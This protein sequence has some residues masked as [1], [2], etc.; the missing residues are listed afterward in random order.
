MPSPDGEQKKWEHP[1]PY[2]REPLEIARRLGWNLERSKKGH[3]FGRLSCPSGECKERIFSTGKGGESFALDLMNLIRN[4]PHRP[5]DV[6]ILAEV[7]L[8]IDDL[9]RWVEAIEVR[10]EQELINREL[11]DVLNQIEHAVSEAAALTARFDTLAA[12]ESKVDRRASSMLTRIS[13]D[14]A[15]LPFA[16][17]FS[18]AKRKA[19][20]AKKS[21]D[22]AGG[23]RADAETLKAEI[24][25]LR[26][27]L[28]VCQ[29][30][31]RRYSL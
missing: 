4:C 1:K 10:I 21:L 5:E 22:Q 19:S 13:V 28:T 31:A 14:P 26:A 9:A 12:K 8:R 25:E 29:K 17:M 2:M 30:N 3:I 23:S 20:D 16:S 24:Q 11:K 6:D 18:T 27:R 7:R 15:S